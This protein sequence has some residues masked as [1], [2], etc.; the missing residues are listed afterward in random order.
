[1]NDDVKSLRWWFPSSHV[2]HVVPTRR[3]SGNPNWHWLL[4]LNHKNRDDSSG[5]TERGSFLFLRQKKNSRS[6]ALTGPIYSLELTKLLSR[7]SIYFLALHKNAQGDKSCDMKNYLFLFCPI[8][9]CYEL[10]L[11]A[12]RQSEVNSITARKEDG[13]IMWMKMKTTRA[14]LWFFTLHPSKW[15]YLLYSDANFFRPC[16]SLAD[17]SSPSHRPKVYTHISHSRL[18][19]SILMMIFPPKIFF[20]PFAYIHRSRLFLHAA[21]SR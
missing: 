13:P 18:F 17:S 5:S 4:R 2:S 11:R 12:L 20:V 7:L 21:L 8:S 1:M 14:S 10:S 15:I 19:A 6:V 3:N 9:S 16:T